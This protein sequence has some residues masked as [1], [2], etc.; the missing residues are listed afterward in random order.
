MEFRQN[1]RETMRE[2]RALLTSD[3]QR[4]NAERV[5]QFVVGSQLFKD[6]HSIA[7]YMPQRGEIHTQSIIE[8]IWAHNK[9]CYLPC[10]IDNTLI[11]RHYRKNTPLISGRYGIP[12][13]DP[14]EST[15]I[16][17]KELDLVLVPVVA[18]DKKGNRLGMGAGYYD[19]TFAFLLDDHSQSDSQHNSRT[20]NQTKLMGL[21]H[22]FQQSERLDPQPWD[23]PM[24]VVVTEQSVVLDSST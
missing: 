8:S 12:E 2:Q 5:A 13:P 6:S 22:D 1:L 19:R 21:A 23:V 11:F 14:L 4:A 17:A 20:S 24:H 18:F 9:Q 16:E 3:V 10:A 7:V 15:V